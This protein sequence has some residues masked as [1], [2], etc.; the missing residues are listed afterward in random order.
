MGGKSVVLGVV[1]AAYL[2]CLAGCFSSNPADIKAFVKPAEVIVTA[3]R[4]VLQPPDEIE[5]HSSKVPE[6]HLQRQQ[7]RPDGKVSFEGVGEIEAAGKTP[8]EVAE[9][10]RTKVL[11][12][13]T[14]PGDKPIDVR[15]VVYRSKVFYVLGQVYLPGPKAYTGRNTVLRALAAAQPNP[16]AWVERIQVIRPS[17]VEGVRPKIFEVNFDRMSAHGDLSKDVALEEGDIVF[18]PPTVL[19]GIA[20]KVEEFVRPIGRAFSTVNIVVGGPGYRE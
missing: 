13:Y 2:F 5:V 8:G 11:Q 9:I 12:L 18:V 10:L 19:A 17:A 1:C 16:M 15:I 3:D 7:I 14:L 20:L 4:Y 6:I